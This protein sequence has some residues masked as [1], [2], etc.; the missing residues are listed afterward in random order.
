MIWHHD[1]FMKQIS[2]LF[3]TRENALNQDFRNMWYSEKLAS[4]PRS[5]GNKIRPP[6]ASPVR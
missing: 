2:S 1:K 6:G 5:G 4:L 3:T